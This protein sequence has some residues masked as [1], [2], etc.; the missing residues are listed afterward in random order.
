MSQQLVQVWIEGVVL[1]IAQSVATEIA[2]A[3]PE[4]HSHFASAPATARLIAKR[5]GEKFSSSAL[6]SSDG[7][8]KR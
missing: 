1:Q 8:P 6:A 3:P 5:L 4:V 7:L 2:S